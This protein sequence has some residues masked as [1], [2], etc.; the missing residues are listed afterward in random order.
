MLPSMMRWYM[1]MTQVGWN[2]IPEDHALFRDVEA[3]CP[4]G[5][6]NKGCLWESVGLVL[7]RGSYDKW[8]EYPLPV[9]NTP[10]RLY[11]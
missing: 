8:K 6:R 1:R 9:R 3:C 10:C 2:V 4:A 11:G 7:G 5:A